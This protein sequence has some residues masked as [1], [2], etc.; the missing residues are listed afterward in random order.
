MAGALA[1]E[2]AI[3]TGAGRGIGR[4]IAEWLAAEGADLVLVSRTVAEVDELASR[5]VAV[6]GVRALGRAVDVARPHDVATAIDE[7]VAVL[8]PISV[9]I[10]NAAILGPVGV[11]AATDPARWT[12]TLEVNVAGTAN[13]VRCVVPSMIERGHGRIVTLSGGGV[14]GPRPAERVSAYVASKAAVI[15]LTEAVAHELPAGVTIN[16]IAPGAVPT[17]FMQEVVERGPEVAGPALH[18]TAAARDEPDLE[19]LRRLLLYLVAGDST[20]VSGC[21][22]SARWDDPAALAELGP[23]LGASSRF[24]LRRI[25]EDLYREAAGVDA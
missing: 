16:A 14:G 17:T 2:V 6:H 15:A 11:L 10:A 21:C 9:A 25:D 12:H 4:T 8:G 5:L 20:H 19:P 18:A 23:A 22:L 13:V 1:G 7:A 3:V 24:R